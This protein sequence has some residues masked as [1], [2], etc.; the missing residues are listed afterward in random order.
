LGTNGANTVSKLTLSTSTVSVLNR[1]DPQ[2]TNIVQDA[3]GN[4]DWTSRGPGV[5]MMQAPS[6]NCAILVWGLEQTVGIALDATGQNRYYTEEPTYGVGNDQGGQNKVWQLNLA[7]QFRTLLNTFEPAP[8]DIVVRL[9]EKI[10]ETSC[11]MHL[12]P[13][14]PNWP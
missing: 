2:P 4:L 13:G 9:T 6:G 7:K 8:T 3:Q 10:S 11:G 14:R 1:G 12:A 5:I